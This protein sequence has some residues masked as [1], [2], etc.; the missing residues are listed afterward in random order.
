MKLIKLT[1]TSR[2]F[3]GNPIYINKDWVVSVYEQPIDG[4]CLATVVYGGPA[5]CCWTVEEGLKEVKD[6]LEAE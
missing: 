5:G 4:G 2:E 1:N 6:M 3:K